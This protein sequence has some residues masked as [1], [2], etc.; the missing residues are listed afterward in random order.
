M[1]GNRH[2]WITYVPDSIRILDFLISCKQLQMDNMGML[3][4]TEAR[5]SA[6]A[7]F[8]NNDEHLERVDQLIG[9]CASGKYIFN[10]S[11]KM[12]IHEDPRPYNFNRN[13]QTAALNRDC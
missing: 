6:K 9:K 8:K 2:I 7:V 10:H 4:A 3:S 12:Q 5:N 1:I 13:R 11:P